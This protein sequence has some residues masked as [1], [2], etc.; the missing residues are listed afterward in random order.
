MAPA[1]RTRLLINSEI[2]AGLRCTRRP[3]TRIHHYNDVG[4][5]VRWRGAQPRPEARHPAR[6]AFVCV[7][8]P[9]TSVQGLTKA[10]T[11]PLTATDSRPRTAST[12]ATLPRF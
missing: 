7:D 11:A 5:S 2:S 8:A 3:D 12:W 1:S 10:Q 4:G 6:P 9:P